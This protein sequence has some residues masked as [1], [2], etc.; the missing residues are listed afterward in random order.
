MKRDPL[1]S[2]ATAERELEAALEGLELLSTSDGR[3]RRELLGWE[4]EE[5]GA[6]ELL[7]AA[8]DLAERARVALL[9]S[10]TLRAREELLEA[11]GRDAAAAGGALDGV[12]PSD[13]AMARVDHEHARRARGAQSEAG[14]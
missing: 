7:E 1:A 3:G 6:V 14:R 12:D 13:L 4:L 2:V 5:A 8:A 10:R 9:L 11:G